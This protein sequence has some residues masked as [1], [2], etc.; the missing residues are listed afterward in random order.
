VATIV[1]E[2][3]AHTFEVAQGRRYSVVV[4]PSN[5]FDVALEY[6]CQT[7]SGSQSATIDSGWEGEPESYTYIAPGAGNCT[8]SVSGYGGSTGDYTISVSS[9]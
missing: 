9:Q 3:I 2:G 6:S 7:G 4:T 8:V 1:R 5:E